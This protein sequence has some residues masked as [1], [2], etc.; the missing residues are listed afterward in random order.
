MQG[1]ATNTEA[2]IARGKAMCIMIKRAQVD[3]SAARPPFPLLHML[4]MGG[5]SGK[6]KNCASSRLNAM[7]KSWPIFSET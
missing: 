3:V 6:W 4:N 7:D 5:H 2:F 1:F